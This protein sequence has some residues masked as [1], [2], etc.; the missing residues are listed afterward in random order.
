M[1]ATFG[2]RRGVFIVTGPTLTKVRSRRV[3]V[4]HGTHSPAAGHRTI[5]CRTFQ[6]RAG[7]RCS[8]SVPPWPKAPQVAPDS[9]LSAGPRR[10]SR[11]VHHVDALYAE[12]R[13]AP[14]ASLASLT[15]VRPTHLATPQFLPGPKPPRS[16]RIAGYRPG[17]VATV[18]R[19]TTW[20]YPTAN[21]GDESGWFLSSGSFRIRERPPPPRSPR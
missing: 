9:R 3:R 7:L 17:R 21:D 1:Q 13:S 14:N 2:K 12:L 4:L 11:P 10:Y 16:L 6:H 5:T 20:T 19:F 18:G 15:G 8:P